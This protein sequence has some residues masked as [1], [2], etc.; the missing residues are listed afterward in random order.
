MRGVSLALNVDLHAR[1]LLLAELGGTLGDMLYP[2]SIVGL[3]LF[4]RSCIWS[5][6]K[7]FRLIPLG[8]KTLAVH[9]GKTSSCC[10]YIYCA[11][12]DN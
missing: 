5:P 8:G 9:S 12:V 10:C 3:S 6:R 1:E 7:V 11:A 2:F 4:R